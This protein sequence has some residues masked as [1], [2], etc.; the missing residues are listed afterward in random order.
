[1]PTNFRKYYFSQKKKKREIET[2][3][4][5][6]GQPQYKSTCLPCKSRETERQEHIH[7]KGQNI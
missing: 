2:T 7:I 4:V 6:W 3:R 5:A 1:M